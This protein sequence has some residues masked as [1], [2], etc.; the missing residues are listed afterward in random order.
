MTATQRNLVAELAAAVPMSTEL[1]AA[2]SAVDRGDFVP[3]YMRPAEGKFLTWPP[4]WKSFERADGDAWAANVYSPFAALVTKL[5]EHGLPIVS[6]TDP[7]LMA[8]MLRS[9]GLRSGDR[10]LEIGT[11]TGYNAA[12]LSRLVGPDG[13]V[14]S[15]DIDQQVVADAASRLTRY[16]NVTLRRGDGR[17]DGPE[18][19]LYAG[20]VVTGNTQW[21]EPAWLA[22]LTVGGALVVNLDGPMVSG[23][24]SGRR[25]SNG[26]VTGAFLDFPLVGFTPLYGHDGPQGIEFPSDVLDARENADDVIPADAAEAVLGRERSPLAFMQVAAEVERRHDYVIH[27][28]DGD[29]T[30]ASVRSGDRIGDIRREQAAGDQQLLVHAYGDRLLL[31]DLARAY[32]SWQEH[33]RPEFWRLKLE[34]DASRTRLK[35]RGRHVCDSEIFVSPPRRA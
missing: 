9:M 4:R 21:I 28:P 24:F 2:F 25:Q 22:Q 19:A 3:C 34:I 16:P 17:F 6:S 18:A 14:V 31:A 15:V 10:V 30:C 1:L 12:V 33:G 35:V 8:V 7:S 11:G 32:R 29:V 13:M 26:A 20:I 27:G 5:S 23:I